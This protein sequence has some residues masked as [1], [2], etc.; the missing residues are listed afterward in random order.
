MYKVRPLQDKVVITCLP[1]CMYKTKAYFNENELD[2]DC[3]LDT[4]M[5][6]LVNINFLQMLK[7]ENRFSI[8]TL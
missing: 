4:Q 2:F 1:T 6:N 3:D 8:G 5:E 7:I